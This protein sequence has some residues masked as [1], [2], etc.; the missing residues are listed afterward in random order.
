MEKRERRKANRN[1]KRARPKTQ[2]DLDA[3]LMEAQSLAKEIAAAID[4]VEKALKKTPANTNSSDT[5]INETR[6]NVTP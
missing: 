1:S 4:V 3:E 5:D 6:D 2:D